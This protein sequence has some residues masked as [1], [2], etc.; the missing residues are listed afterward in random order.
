MSGGATP[1]EGLELFRHP[2]APAV[3]AVV[4]ER[5]YP[6][7]TVADFIAR[8]G[9]EPS[10]F[11][12]QFRDKKDVVLR[13]FESYI[14][15]FEAKVKTAYATSP[16]WP[17]NLRAAAYET[18]RWIRDHPDGTW[19]GMVGALEAGEMA[20]VRREN[21]F[22]WCAGLIDEGRAAAP[23]P[24]AVPEGAPLMA[25]GA[26]VE[27]LTRQV[28]GTIIADPVETV[29]KMMY[30]AVRPYLG[31]GAARRELT[32]PPPADLPD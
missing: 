17:D 23:D 27:I 20:R 2:L 14:D 10:A 3:M 1:L 8:A 21:V 28:Q 32:I 9:I 19:F 11:V 29:P 18:T 24:G 5:G 7:A 12:G 15:D 31:E 4:H 30:G 13:V 22:R 6:D 26:I 16:N 25:V